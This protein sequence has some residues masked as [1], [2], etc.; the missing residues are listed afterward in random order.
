M[1]PR[2]LQKLDQELRAFVGGLVAGMGRAER[3]EAMR[4]Y[5]QGLLLDGERKSME[6]MAA[7]LID[8][9][10]ELVAM[11]Q[12]LQECI[13]VS[14]WDEREVYR[15]LALK[16]EAEMPDVEALVI[17]DTGFAK[18]GKASVGVTR[19]Y[20]GT[21][22]R[23]DNC[24]VA[25]SLHLASEKGSGCIGFRLYLPESWAEDRARREKAGVPDDVVFATKWRLALQ[26]VEQALGWGVR[27]HVVLADAGYGEVTEFREGLAALGLTYVVGVPRG[28]VVWPPETNFRVPPRTP[29]KLGRPAS[30]PVAEADSPLSIEALF[31]AQPRS[32]WKTVTWREGSRGKQSSRF[33]ALR[34]RTAHK[35][36]RGGRPGDEQ[37]VFAQ[38]PRGEKHP[39]KYYLSNLP[40]GTALRS[41][42]RLAKLRWR[43][44]RDYQEMKGELGLDHFEGRSWTGF[45]HHAALCAAAHAF[46][47]LQRALFPPEDSQLD[48]ADGP[49]RPSADPHQHDRDLPALPAS[50][51]TAF[52][53][54]RALDHLIK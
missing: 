50:R 32:A 3:R 30:R 53:A 20:S 11:R 29:G 2:Q 47:S 49:P 13:S 10:S 39:T 9:P 43:V 35:H 12:R 25:T 31:A 17:D 40:P 36:S 1:T 28:I 6:P 19:Q 48:T 45:H 54:K 14:S 23:T 27:K 24:Q 16:L 33:C 7:R 37:W 4:L 51:Y 22:G 34:V 46:L 52:T 26:M 42:V 5:V 41:L 38:W 21:L 44:E 15:K 18:K 8:D